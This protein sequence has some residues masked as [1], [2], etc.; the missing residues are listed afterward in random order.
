MSYASYSESVQNYVN[1]MS[2]YTDQVNQYKD[3]LMQ[4][5]D[6]NRD[7]SQSL[8]LEGAM[9]LISALVEKGSTSLFG[10][11]AGSLAAGIL[12][13]DAT[14]ITNAIKG[15]ADNVLSK[16]VEDPTGDLS[17]LTDAANAVSSLVKNADTLKVSELLQPTESGYTFNNP[18]FNPESAAPEA[19]AAPDAAVA[20]EASGFTVNNPAF[21]PNLDTDL[22]YDAAKLPSEATFDLTAPAEQ[23]SA[24]WMTAGKFEDAANFAST[25]T[26]PLPSGSLTSNIIGRVLNGQMGQVVPESAGNVL[27]SSED[28]ISSVMSSVRAAGGSALETATSGVAAATSAGSQISGSLGEA[29]SSALSSLGTESPLTGIISSAVSAGQKATSAVA[30]ATEALAS[31][32]EVGEGAGLFSSLV[33]IPEDVAAGAEGGPAGLIIGGLIALGTTLAS[34]F[35]HHENA[36]APP[37]M[38]VL[39]IPTIQQ[40]LGTS[41]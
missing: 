3:M 40:G 28:L 24:N 37:A 35:G 10:E 8:D 9:P 31:T 30:T 16:V 25:F 11:D 12:K 18:A 15:V 21:N 6:E 4:T 13:G 14:S 27:P 22:G 32:S 23:F 7:F 5:Q 41:N 26:E 2:N 29:A 20:P 39:S 34:I 33:T 19:S 38:P 17:K 36:P 1:Q